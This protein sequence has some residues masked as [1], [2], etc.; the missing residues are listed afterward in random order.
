MLRAQLQSLT[1]LGEFHHRAY[2]SYPV[3]HRVGLSIASD[4]PNVQ[5]VSVH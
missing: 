5:E 4:W 3:P 1:G 2:S